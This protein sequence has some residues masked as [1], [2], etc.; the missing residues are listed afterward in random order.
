METKKQEL[1]AKFFREVAST[2]PPD[3][4]PLLT[5]VRIQSQRLDFVE[6]RMAQAN[7]M[8][9]HNMFA[10]VRLE[11]ATSCDAITNAILEAKREKTG[12]GTAAI[13]M[14]V[15]G[16]LV[17]LA[18]NVLTGGGMSI[19]GSIISSAGDALQKASEND[20]AGL[21]NAVFGGVT[22][23]VV[24][25]K[26]GKSV[27]EGFN[28]TSADSAPEGKSEHEKRAEIA[29]SSMNTALELVKLLPATE[30]QPSDG[31]QAKY[32][33]TAWISHGSGGTNAITHDVQKAIVDAYYQAVEILANDIKTCA[34][35]KTPPKDSLLHKIAS[36]PLTTAG[37]M[38]S[39]LHPLTDYVLKAA[40]GELHNFTGQ[41]S[42]VTGSA[43]TRAS[44]RR[45]SNFDMAGLP[46][47]LPARAGR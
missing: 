3:L 28:L 5:L 10:I 8:I 15:A 36:A 38:K 20:A 9:A 40:L 47:Q 46:D 37:D 34:Q 33:K 44:T 25:S 43:F 42:R 23:G 19:L 32:K 11:I 26:E 41:Y 7:A 6:A 22:A 39:D 1:T 17:M 30:P 16:T 12:S 35:G 29:A 4:K 21:A 45:A 14:N 31:Y 24:A 27:T 13:A 18:G 2:I